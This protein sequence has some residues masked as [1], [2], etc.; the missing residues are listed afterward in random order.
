MMIREKTIVLWNKKITSPYYNIGIQC[1]EGFS[2]SKPGQFLMLNLQGRH[3]FLRRPFS[4]H[5]LIKKK[6]TVVG[7]ELL[8]KVVGEFTGIL[9]SVKKGEPV[10]I[11]GPLGNGFLFKNSFRRIFIVAGGIGVAPMLFFAL[12]L[13]S[14]GF[15][16]CRSTLFIGGKGQK[17]ILC[18]DTF[19]NMGIDIL[20]ATEDGSRGKKGLVTDLLNTRLKKNVAD[21]IYAC[22]P[23]PMLKQVARIAR[24]DGIECQI[25]TESV[26]ACGVGACLGCAVKAINSSN[27]YMHVCLDGPVFDSANFDIS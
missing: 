1:G 6:G 13:R 20:I 25:S 26:M 3:P 17:D 11:L 10:D 16:L 14:K 21:I 7:V 19:A 24:L 23:V 5:R 22:G 27:R 4:I 9:A 8:Y 12:S 15:D 18:A 2:S